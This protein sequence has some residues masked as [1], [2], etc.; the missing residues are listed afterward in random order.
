M[1]KAF[2]NITLTLFISSALACSGVAQPGA[3][4][5]APQKDRRKEPER[6]VEKK[7]NDDRGDRGG[8]RGDRGGDKRDDG[9]KRGKRP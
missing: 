7:K 1:M 5:L 2:K 6:P 4:L 9:G 8:D 3:N